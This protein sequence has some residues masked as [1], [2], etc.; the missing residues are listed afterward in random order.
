MQLTLNTKNKKRFILWFLRYE[1]ING[2]SFDDSPLVETN[3][4]LA[5]GFL[6]THNFFKSKTLVKP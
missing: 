5:I 1:N 3:N 2:A 4:S 6:Y